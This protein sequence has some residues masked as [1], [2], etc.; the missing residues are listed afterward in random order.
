MRVFFFS[1]IEMRRVVFK[2]EREEK[3]GSERE[4]LVIKVDNMV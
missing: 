2:C 1:E 3:R 4:W